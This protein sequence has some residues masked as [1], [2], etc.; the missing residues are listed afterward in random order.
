MTW[1]NLNGYITC[2]DPGEHDVSFLTGANYTSPL[3]STFQTVSYTFAN[4][5]TFDYYC[6]IHPVMKAEVTVTG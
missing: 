6:T 2:C 5:G 4:D 3:I 1:I